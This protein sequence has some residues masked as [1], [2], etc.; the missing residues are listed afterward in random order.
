MA[1]DGSGHVL[2]DQQ[3][4]CP[5]LPSRTAVRRPDDRTHRDRRRTA[6]ALT[7]LKQALFGPHIGNAHVRSTPSRPRRLARRRGRHALRR[8]SGAS[9]GRHRPC[10]PRQRAARRR[11][12]G[13]PA[14]TP[15]VHGLGLGCGAT[16]R[17]GRRTRR[18]SVCVSAYRGVPE[19]IATTALERSADAIVLGSTRHR[20]LGRLFS[21]QVRERTTR[22][23][24]LPVLTA[25]SP[26]KVT[27]PAGVADW[28]DGLGQVVDSLLS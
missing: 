7:W 25:P 19:R 5:T 24:A 17:R 10:A 23:T 28:P 9:H 3:S 8:R 16:A 21:P 12:R 4:P 6:V 11:Q 27:S 26:L 2:H 22:L 15:G 13:D 20:R 1:H 18:G 14:H